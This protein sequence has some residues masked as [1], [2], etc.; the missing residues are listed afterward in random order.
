M[1][2][3]GFPTA[4]KGLQYL[5]AGHDLGSVIWLGHPCLLVKCAHRLEFAYSK[6]LLHVLQPWPAWTWGWEMHQTTT[7]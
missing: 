3:W 5:F 2:G 7:S 4:I 6:S 1:A